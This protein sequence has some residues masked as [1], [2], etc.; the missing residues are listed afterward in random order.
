M[1]F[2]YILYFVF[3]G[4]VIDWEARVL[5][6]RRITSML[7]QENLYLKNMLKKSKEENLQLKNLVSC[8]ESNIN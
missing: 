3:V 6:Y 1:Y 5:T 7:Q 2:L 8:Y 4:Y